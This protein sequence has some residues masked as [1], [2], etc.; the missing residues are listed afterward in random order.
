MSGRWGLALPSPLPSHFTLTE[1]S[2]R[3]LHKRS[4]KEITLET[5]KLQSTCEISL[6]H[7]T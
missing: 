7:E 6:W 1:A 2:S 4:G 3:A 5:S